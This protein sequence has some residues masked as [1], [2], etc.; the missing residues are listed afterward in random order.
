MSGFIEVRLD[1]Q[2]V[3]KIPK[4]FGKYELIKKI[5]AG[6]FSA[7]VLCRHIQTRI[8]YACKVVS[9]ALLVE[10]HIFDR[11][12]QEVRILQS[13]KHPNIVHVEQIVF[14]E[15]NI[16]LVMEYCA[17]GE[18]F[19]HIVNTGPLEESEARRLF[20]QMT[21]G[22]EFVHA[23]NIAHR[24]LKPEN[25]LLDQDMN[26]KL[27]D[28]GLC[29]ATSAE[30]LLLTP[31]GS[32]FY[33]PPEIISNV[34]Y[35][36]KKADIWSLG[37]VLYTMATGSLPWTETNQTQLFIQI[38]EADII[39]PPRLNPALRNLLDAMIQRDPSRRPSCK[40]ILQSEWVTCDEEEVLDPRGSAKMKRALSMSDKP[41]RTDDSAKAT[42]SNVF[43]RRP[44]DARP[45]G[46]SQLT[47]NTPQ[48]ASFSQVA[49][50][51]T[52]IRKVPSS[53]KKRVPRM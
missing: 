2:N 5:G 37:V 17:K 16:Y 42:Q 31:C 33:A 9:R 6:S 25:I 10:Q 43:T 29:H 41:R 49:S 27:A 39:I 11:F 26:A 28:F 12:E 4:Q 40:E 51:G 50:I 44:S 23:H 15:E 24:D 45:V 46:A 18:L 8:Y 35:D 30:Q 32:P 34:K 1:E 53:G 20:R 38:Q 48:S 21:E 14:T 19:K 7:V 3:L 52:L 13:F 47:K 22:L 36:G